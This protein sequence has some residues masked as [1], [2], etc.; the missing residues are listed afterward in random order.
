[1]VAVQ[2]QGESDPHADAVHGGEQRLVESAQPIHER[3]EAGVLAA[4]AAAHLAQVLSGRERTLRARDDDGV[5]PGVVLGVTQ[6]I[7]QLGPHLAVEGVALPGA[8]QRE[9]QD[10]PVTFL[11]DCFAH[12]GAPYPSRAGSA[13][14]RAVL[15]QGPPPCAA[16]S[17]GARIASDTE[18]KALDCSTGICLWR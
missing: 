13:T 6:R 8:V 15:L 16:G 12:A 14:L 3:A 18:H 5:N 9:E 17:L 1:H 2:E 7:A 4:C 11:E 10:R